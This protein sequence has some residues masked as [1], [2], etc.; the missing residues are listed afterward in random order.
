MF[1][2]NS[3]SCAS[4]LQKWRL[5]KVWV[6]AER[7]I[8]EKFYSGYKCRAVLEG[9]ICSGRWRNSAAKFSISQHLMVKEAISSIDIYNLYLPIS[10]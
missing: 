8:L 1:I 9:V 4:L 6:S 7:T 3:Q 10:L 5:T 2:S